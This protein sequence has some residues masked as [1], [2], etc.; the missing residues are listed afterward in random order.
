MP[1]SGVSVENVEKISTATGAAME[2]VLS[3]TEL[4]RELTAT[5]A[6]PYEFISHEQANQDLVALN[7][8]GIPADFRIAESRHFQQETCM[9]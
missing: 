9:A 6:V 1:S 3:Q 2:I 8:E 4:L 5:Q 7:E